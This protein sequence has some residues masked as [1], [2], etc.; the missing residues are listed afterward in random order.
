MQAGSS[1][2]VVNKHAL[3]GQL[4]DRLEI[5][6]EGEVLPAQV[7]AQ[8]AAK[9]CTNVHPVGHPV[10]LLHCAAFAPSCSCFYASLRLC[11]SLP[12]ML[13]SHTR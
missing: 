10:Q 6:M 8:H 3:P 12:H 1:A 13:L 4:P 7:A 5:E 2:V 11:C 9:Y